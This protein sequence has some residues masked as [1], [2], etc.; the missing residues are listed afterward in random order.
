MIA[1]DTFQ[2]YLCVVLLV[3]FAIL[4]D[5]VHVRGRDP[6]LEQ[7]RTCQIIALDMCRNTSGD[8]MNV[9][10]ITKS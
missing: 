8:F 1:Y 4:M 3:V 5:H 9:F 2:Q 6:V 10:N 7:I